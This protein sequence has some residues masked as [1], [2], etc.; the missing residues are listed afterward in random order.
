MCI[1]DR[2][3]GIRVGDNPLHKS[4]IALNLKTNGFQQAHPGLQS[5]V[6]WGIAQ[7]LACKMVNGG[8]IELSVQNIVIITIMYCLLMSIPRLYRQIMQLN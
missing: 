2:L 3:C 5:H 1:R 6:T 7:C 8:S 4:Q